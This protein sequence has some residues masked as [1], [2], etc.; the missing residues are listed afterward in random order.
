[1][2]TH[3]Q[4]PE[5]THRLRS[6]NSERITN[7]NA[8]NEI[9][10]QIAEFERN[11][12]SVKQIPAGISAL[13]PGEIACGH[14]A[15]FMATPRKSQTAKKAAKERATLK[16]SYPNLVSLTEAANMLG[17]SHN[18][19]RGWVKRGILKFTTQ[20][21]ES[22]R[23]KYFDKSHIESVRA[24]RSKL[25]DPNKSD[26][27]NLSQAAK[28]LCVHPVTIGCWVKKGILT[29]DKIDPFNPHAKLLKTSDVLAL[30]ANLQQKEEQ[31]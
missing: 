28:I 3:A 8:S 20:E 27:I 25:S 23:E 31:E 13:M 26:L 9:A 6:N 22:K 17:I 11:G 18:A 16:K 12:G 15:E 30:K 29:M 10:Q 19:A 5:F 1:M 14:G 4:R 2:Q 24:A 21:T 7:R